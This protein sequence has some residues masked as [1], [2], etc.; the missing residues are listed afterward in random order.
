MWFQGKWNDNIFKSKYLDLGVLQFV[1][2]AKSCKIDTV[3]T[4]NT[5]K[6]GVSYWVLTTR[7]PLTIIG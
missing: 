2:R 5:F 7:G 4:K 6:K 3:D 1:I